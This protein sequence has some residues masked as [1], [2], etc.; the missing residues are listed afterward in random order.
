MKMSNLLVLLAALC[1]LGA[2]KGSGSYDK[3]SSADTVSSELNA[4]EAVSNNS[5]KLV[6]TAEMRF[7]VKNVQKSSEA[8]TALTRSYRGMVVHQNM[9]ATVVDSQA[10]RLRNDSLKQ[11]SAFSA[12]ANIT[13]K[14]PSDSLD[15]FLNKVS[16]LGIY[17]NTRRM[18]IEDKT[19]DYLSAKL[20]RNN[21]A[22]I[23]NKQQNWE[24]NVKE[25]DA[26]LKLKDDMVDQKINNS[27]IDE[28]VRFSV[29][30]LSLYQSNTIVQE[31]IPNDNASFYQVSFFNQ[32][33]MALEN[34][35]N[36]FATVI[37]ALVNLWVF[38]IAGFAAWFIF[39]FYKRKAMPVANSI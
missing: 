5:A 37:I 15:Q 35:W 19:I 38:V 21:R 36:M 22:Q 16:H 25:A 23:A 8:I 12:T 14:I 28:A 27:R 3:V 1:L 30:D 13:V 24:P 10:S 11:V 29:V 7:K 32:L 26:M 33:Y 4:S 6:K 31:I 2:C 9:E 39:R 34:G 20:K 18:D 17:V